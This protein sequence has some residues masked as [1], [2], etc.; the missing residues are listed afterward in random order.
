[1]FC[2]KGQLYVCLCSVSHPTSSGL[3]LQSA[4]PAILGK[5][6]PDP[7]GKIRMG[8]WLCELTPPCSGL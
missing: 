2:M 4:M 8:Q 7:I 1:M 5:P 6:D 3:R